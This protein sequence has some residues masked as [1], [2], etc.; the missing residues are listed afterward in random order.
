MVPFP[1]GPHR[2]APLD[3]HTGMVPQEFQGAA[4][5]AGADAP[6]FRVRAG[7]IFESLPTGIPDESI[8]APPGAE[9][10]SRRRGRRAA[11]RIVR[12]GDVAMS[13]S[14]SVLD[15]L[16]H[17]IHRRRLL[18]AAGAYAI[19]CWFLVQTAAAALPILGAPDWA[20][21]AMLALVLLGLPVVLGVAW[22]VAGGEPDE[23][24][25]RRRPGWSIA[26]TGSLLVLLV[27]GAGARIF[28]ARADL[29]TRE[30]EA[31]TRGAA[32]P[33]SPRT[34]A[35]LPLETLSPDRRDAYFSDGIT[36]EI[37]NAVAQVPGLTLVARSSAFAFRGRTDDLRD[38][39]TKL[40]AGSVLE[41][42]VRRAGQRV[43]ID[44][45]LVDTGT[46][47]EIWR[48]SYDQGL[49]D[50]FALEDEIAHDVAT[51]LEVK[52]TGAPP[53]AA[54]ANVPA[55][56][57]YL[58]GL[59]HWNR[60][61]GPEIRQAIDYFKRAAQAD[62][63]FARAYAGL[64]S[65]YV[66]LP[67]Y[68]DVPGEEAY[69]RARA[70]AEQAL[71]LDSTLAEAHTA[72]AS[73]RMIYGWDWKGADEEFRRAI[74]LD[75]SYATAHEWRA[76]LL[77]ELGRPDSAAAEY[78]RART[79]DPMSAIIM[80]AAALHE[81]LVGRPR[82]AA[83]GYRQALE[84]E[85][86]LPLALGF[87]AQAEALAGRPDSAR[88]AQRRWAA[89]VQVDPA[90]AESLVRGLSDPSAR[91]AGLAALSDTALQRTL[92][93]Y[94]LATWAAMLGDSAVALDWLERAAANHDYLLFAVR[95]DPLL[96]P[97]H[98]T[99]RFDALLARLDLPR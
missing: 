33:P 87:L 62:P 8:Q 73:V 95:E 91:A 75:P 28:R 50:I 6:L 30:R 56:D 9:A 42:S 36:V 17:E 84:R 80:V 27:L 70:A 43:R 61:T 24:P 2:T 98:G 76:Q 31:L 69:P 99:P 18:Q 45:A 37:M 22:L 47:R 12:E 85:P 20:A 60:R 3:N 71:A 41:G 92:K 34:I 83:A 25:E 59:Y 97:L 39:R 5:R 88:A 14:G 38:V 68:A 19:V 53:R 52:L 67:L 26:V 90:Q 89:A 4:V 16:F 51:A 64:A 86:G 54:T 78:E 55:H 96:R 77:D 66:L 11:G 29:A 48:Q 93:P 49:G 15:R 57:L 58:L 10:A 35:V 94:Q 21:R 23:G 44:L 1:G 13:G 7:G 40:G 46:G 81:A 82:A 32:A 72:L 63:S 79:A 74:A 65:A